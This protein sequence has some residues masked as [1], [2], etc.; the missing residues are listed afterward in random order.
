MAHVPVGVFR[1]VERP[2]YDDLVRTQVVDAAGAAGGP[3]SDGD[4]RCAARR[5]GHLA[6]LLTLMK[7][8]GSAI[9]M[10]GAPPCS[11]RT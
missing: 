6:R 8:R 7:G 4:S 1:S 2:T 10:R 5:V 9:T 11:G 3:A